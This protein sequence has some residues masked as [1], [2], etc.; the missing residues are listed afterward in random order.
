MDPLTRMVENHIW[1]T[2]EMIERAA[3]LTDDQLDAP[4]GFTAYDDK[5]LR[6]LLSRIV[7]QLDLWT[8]TIVGKRY[9]FSIEH[10][11]DV[12]A[13]RERFAEVAPSFLA[14]VDDVVSSGRLDETVDNT[15]REPLKAFTYGEMI[16]HVLTFAAHNRTVALLTL[17]K[18]GVTDLDMCISENVGSEC[19]VD[20]S[21]THV[22]RYRVRE[23]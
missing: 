6:R 17:K 13:L 21:L 9:D 2:G 22:K 20:A 19:P 11:E 23:A 1:M 3:R 14:T 12:A 18:A 15:V 4:I 8:S 7:G 10:D 5:T 16:E